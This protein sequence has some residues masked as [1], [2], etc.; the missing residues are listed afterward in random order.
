MVR[1]P[2]AGVVATRRVPARSPGDAVELH[3]AFLG[4]LLERVVETRAAVTVFH[5][6]EPADSLRA[7]LPRP[8]P[9]VAQPQ[10][11]PGE[12]MVASFRHLLEKPGSRAV[13]ISSSSPDLP[14][15]HIRHAFQRLKHRDV[16]IGPAVDGGF[17]L[18]GLRSLAPG[19]LESIPRGEPPVFAR[20]VAEVD[21]LGLSLSLLPP[22]YK[23]DDAGSLEFLR[24]LCAA[25]R[26]AGGVALRRTEALLRELTG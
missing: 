4:D 13:V 22:W 9:V 3:R 10:D 25:R 12:R 20:T 19:W 16:V 1:V 7:L 2:E 24:A 21:R 26:T 11:T 15:I 6:G 5:P 14:L 8:W 18:I 17:Y 23:V